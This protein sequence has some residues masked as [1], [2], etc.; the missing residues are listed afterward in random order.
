MARGL[1]E[2]VSVLDLVRG[3]WEPEEVL[4][5][6][7]RTAIVD[8][9][10]VDVILE[11]EK[12]SSGK[13]LMEAVRRRLENAGVGMVHSRSISGDKTTKGI[14]ARR[15]CRRR[16]SDPGFGAWND[17]VERE[18]NAFPGPEH[19]DIIDALSLGYNWLDENPQV[20]GSGWVPR[21]ANEWRP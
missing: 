20:L 3:R 1:G 9:P 11:E 17:D 14:R 19:D 18:M 7:V 2:E 5:Q 6:I 8:G 16:E 10:A 13:L 4:N 15:L 12:G 21:L